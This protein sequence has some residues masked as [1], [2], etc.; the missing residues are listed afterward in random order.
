MPRIPYRFPAKG[1]DEVADRIRERRGPARGLTSLDGTL[2]NAPMVADGWNTFIG[3]LRQRNSLPDD[4]REILVSIQSRYDLIHAERIHRSLGSRLSTEQPLNGFITSMSAVTLV[5]LM[6][7][8]PSSD[9]L[10]P[11]TD[12]RHSSFPHLLPSTR[13]RHF[14]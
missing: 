3:T 5:Y 4:I 7:N 8:S 2:L 12:L 6:N 1:E 9:R 13:S 11:T 10:R 14:N